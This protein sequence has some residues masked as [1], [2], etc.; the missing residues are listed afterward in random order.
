[1]GLGSIYACVPNK[2]ASLLGV[3]RSIDAELSEPSVG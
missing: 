2:K 3:C 1:M